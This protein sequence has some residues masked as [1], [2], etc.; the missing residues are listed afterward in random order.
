[1]FVEIENAASK[2]NWNSCDGTDA[3]SRCVGSAWSLL[4]VIPLVFIAATTAIAQTVPEPPTLCA[5]ASG[6]C[7]PAND[8]PPPPASGSKK[9]NPGH[10]LKPQGNHAQGDTEAYL[11]SISTQIKKVEDSPEVRGATIAYAWGVVE[12]SLGNYNWEPIYRHL[13]Y[14][15]ARGK[16]MILSI[17]VKCF[18]TN[19]ANLAPANLSGEVFVT[20]RQSPTS[21]IELWEDANMDAYIALWHALGDEFDGHPALEMVLGAESTP[22]LGG[23]T[24]AGYSTEIYADQLK[25]MYSAQAEAFPSTNVAA[26]VNFLGKEVSGLIE[27]AYQV[28]A[29]RGLPD[30]FD[31]SGSFVFRGEC[32]SS[33]DCG[34]RDYRGQVP[35]FGV[36]STPTLRGKHSDKTDT[37]DE[38]I[39]YGLDN[40][41]THYGWVTNED[42]EDSWNSIIDSVESMNPDAHTACPRVYAGCN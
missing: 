13:D 39:N 25:R 41:F 11:N 10:Y 20:P 32:T 26:N 12:P 6:N 2:L 21:I 22:S 9:W 35:H 27:H 42:G 7:G 4:A 17:N 19:C 36:V 38:V 33:G 18:S 34:V 16:K 1:M 28:G 29:G 40:A 37:P 30:I 23:S 31:S 24:P 14:L 3:R 5:D 8:P 15:A